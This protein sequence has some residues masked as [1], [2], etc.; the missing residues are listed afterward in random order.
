[1]GWHEPV[2]NWLAGCN[3]VLSTCYTPS[4]QT[5]LCAAACMVESAPVLKLN[6]KRS[7]IRRV[8]KETYR[9]QNRLQPFGE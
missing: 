7:T 4:N 9:C 5:F 1:M 6:K 3:P 8:Q 2:R